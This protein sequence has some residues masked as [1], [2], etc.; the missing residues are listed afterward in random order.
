P[1]VVKAQ[2]VI[3]HDSCPHTRDY[4][5]MM[6]EFMMTVI[7]DY[8]AHLCT[9]G[10][11]PDH[12]LETTLLDASWAQAC[13]VTGVNLACTPQLAKLVTSCRSQVCSQL[14]TK[15][16]PLVEVMFGF[17]SSQ[18]KNAIKKN[19]ALVEGLKEGM[20]F[21]FKV[22]VLPSTYHSEGQHMALLMQ[23]IVN[24][25]WFANKHDDGVMFYDYFK[26]FPLLALALVLAAIK[27]CIDEWVMGTCMDIAFTIQEYHGT[28]ESHLKCLCA[29]EDA[30]KLYNILP[31]ICT[32]LY[33]VRWYIL[34]YYSI[35]SGAGPVSA[36]A[37]VTV[38]AHVIATAIKEH[39]DGSTTEGESN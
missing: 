4:D 39:E 22:Q 15:L 38:S 37:K 18:S 11:M 20:N 8:H 16:H 1:I 26:P 2:K 5:N 12:A 34:M 19:Q 7:S 13:K 23:K 14:K 17:H 29:F 27:C 10:P 6:Q 33:E 31:G 35:H 9:K 21:A 3:E 30:M 25:M 28:Y 32:R 36:P 24:T